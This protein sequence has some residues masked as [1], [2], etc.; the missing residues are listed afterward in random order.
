MQLSEFKNYGAYRR[1]AENLVRRF[2]RD[3]NQSLSRVEVGRDH[4]HDSYTRTDSRRISSQFLEITSFEV[5]RYSRIEEKTWREADADGNGLVTA[6]ELLAEYG[7]HKDRNGDGKLGFWERVGM[8]AGRMVGR[9]ETFRVVERVLGRNL[10]YSPLPRVET[11]YG[12]PTPPRPDGYRP[13]P[14]RPDMDR[15]APPRPDGYRPSPPRP[16]V[17]RPAP[18]R[19]DGYRPSPPRPDVDRPAPSR[20]DG[21]RPSPPSPSSSRP[22]PPRPDIL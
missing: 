3:G 4:F 5:D 16:D 1:E 7:R 12:R 6:D 8:S 17:D 21:Y 18:P 13:S 11:D 2:D 9:L 20:P 14:P 10:V 15:P 19:P 22:T